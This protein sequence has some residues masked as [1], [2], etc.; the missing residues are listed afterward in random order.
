M[1]NLDHQEWEFGLQLNVPIGQRLAH[2]GVR[3]AELRLARERSILRAQERQAT[4]ELATA[5]ARSEQAT[6]SL[7]ASR[8][9]MEAARERVASLDAAYEADKVSLDLL[10]DAQERLSAAETRYYD[11]LTGR[12]I[13][14]KDVR[15]ADGS[16][17]SVHGVSLQ[18]PEG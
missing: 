2:A 16:L 13:A 4:H 1:E 15:R 8:A 10:L 3:H 12:A 6:N 14:E 7:E 11:V 5:I 17:L 18:S 9:R